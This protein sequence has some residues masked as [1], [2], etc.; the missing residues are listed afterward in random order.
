MDAAKRLGQLGVEVESSSWCG[1]I[2]LRCCFWFRWCWSLWCLA[3]NFQIGPDRFW[4]HGQ[5][6]L[7]LQRLGDDGKRPASLPECTNQRVVGSELTAA[8]FGLGLGE[9]VADLLFDVHTQRTPS[10]RAV[11]GS[12]VVAFWQQLAVRGSLRIE[13]LP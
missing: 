4:I 8:G 7:I 10:I 5:T 12:R 2:C 11:Y 13:I 6:E 3:S 9:K 1:R